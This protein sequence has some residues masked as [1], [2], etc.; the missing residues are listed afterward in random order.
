MRT[1][2]II[3]ALYPDVSARMSAYIDFIEEATCQ[4]SDYPP[5]YCNSGHAVDRHSAETAARFGDSHS[6]PDSSA[7]DVAELTVGNTD[8]FDV[9]QASGFSGEAGSLATDNSKGGADTTV[10]GFLVS[11]HTTW[12]NNN[13]T[14]A[15]SDPF[16]F[17][18]LSQPSIMK[19]QQQ[20]QSSSSKHRARQWMTT[21]TCAI[22]ATAFFLVRQAVWPDGTT[23]TIAPGVSDV[24]LLLLLLHITGSKWWYVRTQD[25]SGRVKDQI[26]L[27]KHG[28]QKTMI[29]LLGWK[30]TRGA[31]GWQTRKFIAFEKAAPTE[32]RP[33]TRMR[34]K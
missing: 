28:S 9:A 3:S 22:S 32:A 20:Q 29:S 6:T 30:E 18:S 15:S 8:A 24:F 1:P 21:T 2:I 17:Q 4:L 12:S 11:S 25:T 31:V 26:E 13:T 16:S 33:P 34:G 27:G 14:D 23:T 19:N 10:N 5:S 7:F